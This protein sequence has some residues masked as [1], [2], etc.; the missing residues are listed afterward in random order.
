MHIIKLLSEN[1]SKRELFTAILHQA[2]TEAALPSVVE[3]NESEI[4]SELLAR[5]R[6][7]DT[8]VAPGIVLAHARISELKELF[9]LAAILSEPMD[10]NSENQVRLIF[11]L[12]IPGVLDAKGAKRSRRLMHF[13]AD[14]EMCADMV[15]ADTPEEL[16]RILA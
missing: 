10:W 13:L 7:G 15:R 4:M 8:S 5:E 14:D 6:M 11:M 16:Q 9:L 2:G 12:L 3:E 1:T